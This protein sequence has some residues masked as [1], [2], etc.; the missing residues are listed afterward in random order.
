MGVAQSNNVVFAVEYNSDD[1]IS[2]ITKTASGGK[3]TLI[4]LEYDA[5]GN[6]FKQYEEGVGTTYYVYNDNKVFRAYYGAVP[7]SIYSEYTWSNGNLVQ[8]S[9]FY[10]NV[11]QLT[12]KNPSYDDKANA[13]HDLEY[14]MLPAG[15]LGSLSKNNTL[16][17]ITINADGTS[18]GS[19]T[20]SYTYNSLG[21]V[22]TSQ[23]TTSSGV[24][25]KSK[26]YY[27]E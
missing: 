12:T 15:I 9:S 8:Q 2:K 27:G 23:V 13:L 26:Y 19:S 10:G 25:A 14:F 5:Q 18:G 6:L 22:A 20:Y 24:I 3:P 21:Y 16:G 1:R 11:L 4:T 17:G 7:S